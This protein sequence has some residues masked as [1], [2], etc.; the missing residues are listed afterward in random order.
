M[1]HVCKFVPDVAVIDQKKIVKNVY[2]TEPDDSVIPW[3]CPCCTRCWLFVEGGKKGRCPWNGPF[4]GHEVL[5][6]A[7][8][9]K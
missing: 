4:T 2:C 7:L 6:A 3:S 1:Q 8:L 5:C 9:P